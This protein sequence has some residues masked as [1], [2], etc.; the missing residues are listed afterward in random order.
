M[1]WMMTMGSRTVEDRV[2]SPRPPFPFIP[3][4]RPSHFSSPPR[5]RSRQADRGCRDRSLDRARVGSPEH[6]ARHRR[7]ETFSLF[8]AGR[9][10]RHTLHRHSVKRRGHGGSCVC[11]AGSP[12]G[13]VRNGR[14]EISQAAPVLVGGAVVAAGGDHHEGGIGLHAR[15]GTLGGTSAC[16]SR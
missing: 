14:A 10:G 5:D 2:L 13:P 1:V 8:P 9:S 11:M 3:F 12:C 7:G 4:K 15:R 16:D 6:P